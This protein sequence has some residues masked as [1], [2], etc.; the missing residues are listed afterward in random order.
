MIALRETESVQRHGPQGGVR[1]AGARRP[2]AW[3][4]GY[5]QPRRS[6]QAAA[7]GYSGIALEWPRGGFK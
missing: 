4:G 1:G 7:G 2:V 6:V 3:R 5:W